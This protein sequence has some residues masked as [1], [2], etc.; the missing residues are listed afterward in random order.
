MFNN[1]MSRR[2]FLRIGAV[3]ICGGM[4]A[5]CNGWFSAGKPAPAPESYYIAKREK[6]LKEVD[7]YLD[8]ILEVCSEKYGGDISTLMTT[9][10]RSRFE[11]MLPGLPYIGG[12][13]NDLT[14]NL[15]LG[16]AT[17]AFYQVMLNNHLT[18]EETGEILYCA[19]ERMVRADPFNGIEGRLVSSDMAKDKFR[20]EALL[21]QE[22]KYPEDWVFEFIE[23]DGQ[24][25]DYGIDY[26][27][28]GILKYFQKQGTAELTP[29]LCLLD[30]PFS[31]AM[32]TGLVRTSTLAHGADRC[33]F[34]Y[35]NNRPCQMEWTPDFLKD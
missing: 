2:N 5:S 34:R 32:N 33:D 30:F 11:E 8:Y 1:R 24:S 4:M 18:L 28:C 9:D 7:G 17:L 21:S 23:G 27:E 3:T 10:A 12:D 19:T 20:R 14:S 35:K 29:Y 16:A 25:F 26:L 22:R 15:Y 13:G 31:R 6:I